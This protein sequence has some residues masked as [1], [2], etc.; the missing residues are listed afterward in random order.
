MQDSHKVIF[1]T[2]VTYTRSFITVFITLYSTKIIINE[3][4]VEDFGLYSLVGGVVGML[5]F[6]S[7]ALTTSTQRYISV[8]IGKGY[9]N[10][11][12]KVVANSIVIH[13]L[14]GLLIATLVFFVGSYLIN[15]KLVIPD[16]RIDATLIVFY[17][18]IASTFVTIISVPFEAVINAHEN[19]LFLAIVGVTEVLLKLGAALFLSYVQNLD[20]LVVYAVL[21]FILLFLISLVKWLYCMYKYK[22]TKISLKRYFSRKQIKEQIGFVGWNLFGA[23]CAMGRGHGIAIISNLFFGSVVNAAYGIANQVKAQS[24]FFSI[25]VLNVLNPQI[26][27]SEGANDRDRML[28][29]SM[30]ANKFGFLLLAF[31]A[32]PLMFEMEHIIQLWLGKTPKYVVNF[33][34]LILL[35][36]LFEQLTVGFKSAVQSVG[37]IKNYQIIIGS[38]ILLNL[39]LTYFFLHIGYPAE[40]ALLIFAVIEFIVSIIRIKLTILITGLKLN[41]YLKRVFYPILIPVLSSLIICYLFVNNLSFQYRFIFTFGVS[42]LCFFLL[43]FYFSLCSDEKLVLIKLNQKIKDKY[44]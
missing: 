41:T 12:K 34:V 36:S 19:F 1:N 33:C 13:L 8:N 11:I 21:L 44:F 18:V 4:G 23:A 38:I 14:I 22:E 9:L 2:V 40:I 17:F 7:S 16:N 42:S 27:K 29:I 32:I 43:I 3:L 31:F 37:N 25:T 24:S 30:M 10:E 5:A 15:N 39:P 28:K 6:F 20:K 26:M 35:G